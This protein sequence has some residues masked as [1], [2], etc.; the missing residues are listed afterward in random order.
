MQP[1]FDQQTPEPDDAFRLDRCAAC[2]YSLVGLPDSGC[3]PECGSPYD[4]SLIVVYGYGVGARETAVNARKT[5]LT[6]MI[7]TAIAVPYYS[8]AFLGGRVDPIY[9]LVIW[10]V[11]IAAQT[12][13]WI[14]RARI[15]GD[16]PAPSQLRLSSAGYEQRDGPGPI[17]LRA[18]STPR[19][20][21]TLMPM[22][23]GFWRITVNHS[24]ITGR[25]SKMPIV[26]FELKSNETYATRL[27]QMIDQWFGGA[28]VRWT[29]DRKS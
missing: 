2:G 12:I 26:Q 3:C 21:I 4:P 23:S 20:I 16:T 29:A 25:A 1:T 27:R 5:P 18:W 10:V 9:C 6:L 11:L 7:C 22:K 19:E 15:L 14:R 13:A 24:C 17:M 28:A 8:F